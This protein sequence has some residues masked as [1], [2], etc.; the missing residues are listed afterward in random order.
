MSLPTLFLHFL[1]SFR[2]PPTLGNQ[3]VPCSNGHM[4]SNPQFVHTPSVVPRKLKVGGLV[5]QLALCSKSSSLNEM[6][7]PAPIQQSFPRLKGIAPCT[8]FKPLFLK[9]GDVCR[10]ANSPHYV[11]FARASREGQKTS[12]KSIKPLHYRENSFIIFNSPSSKHT[13]KNYPSR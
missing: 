12:G 3:L 9:L 4:E 8:K 5:W 2:T 6:S 10:K 13:L 7:L 11:S 1:P